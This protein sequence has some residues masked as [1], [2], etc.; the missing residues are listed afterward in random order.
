MTS[1]ADHLPFWTAGLPLLALTA[2]I[3]SPPQW[4]LPAVLLSSATYAALLWLLPRCRFVKG[5]YL[6]PLNLALLLFLL[7]LV[8]LP[9]LIMTTGPTAGVLAAL[10]SRQ[11]MNAALL[12]E[13]VAFV[14]FC[15]GVHFIPDRPKPPSAWSSALATLGRTPR[16]GYVVAFAVIGAVGFVAAFGTVGVL[17]EYFTNPASLAD[18]K[19]SSD[20]TWHGFLGTVLRPFLAFSLVLIWSRF[21]DLCGP[22]GDWRRP[23]LVAIPVAVGIIVANLTFDFNRASF[24][25]PLVSLAAVFLSRVRRV[26]PLVLGAL[27]MAVIPLLLGVASY[28]STMSAAPGVTAQDMVPHLSIQEVSEQAQVYGSAPQFLGYFFDHIGWGRSLYW[29]RTLVS[30]LL[31]PVPIL[32]KRFRDT[33]GTAVYNRAIYGSIEAQDQIVSFQGELFSN[34]HIIGVAVGF[35]LLGLFLGESQRWF[36]AA[37]SAFGAFAVQYVSLWAAMLIVWSLA[38]FSQILIFCCWPIIVFLTGRFIEEWAARR[39]RMPMTMDAPADPRL[40]LEGV[41]RLG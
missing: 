5:H 12:V 24:V 27:G 11:T 18:L 34:F 22:R 8:I 3:L 40:P 6:C 36:S 33:S 10:P 4:R 28:R 31:S 7:K 35:F 30:S 17:V 26:S 39:S 41:S 37:G 29:G 38:V 2:L 20:G 21:V 15:L 13:V 14:A 9:V 1:V 23:A 32:G 25:F 19:E 16:A